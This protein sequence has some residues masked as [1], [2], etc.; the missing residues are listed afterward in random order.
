MEP[1][2]ANQLTSALAI[3]RLGETQFIQQYEQPLGGRTQA[4]LIFQRAEVRT[5]HAL[6]MLS[7]YGAVFNTVSP[8]VVPTLLTE[9]AREYADDPTVVP[10]LELL[11]GSLTSCECEHCRSVYSPAAYLTD[12]LNFLKRS[13]LL[14]DFRRR[15]P[16]IGAIELTCANTHT[17]LPYIDLVNE[18]L[19]TAAT[20]KRRLQPASAYIGDLTQKIIS[21]SLRGAIPELSAQA[22]VSP[23]L[24][25]PIPVA[26]LEPN[27]EI[28]Q[29]W[30][31]HDRNR[32]YRISRDGDA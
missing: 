7:K 25:P 10:D 23:I 20:P 12:G 18:V 22:R 16:D 11:F 13:T 17:P 19:E 6:A 14:D 30:V 8:W 29:H 2:L 31:I 24:E 26:P 4:Q 5:S 9:T 21:D 15:R 28:I 27:P 3:T 32:V 1:L